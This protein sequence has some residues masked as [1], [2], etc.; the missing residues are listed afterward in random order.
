M[1]LTAHAVAHTFWYFILIVL[2]KQDQQT[3]DGAY[4]T[5]GGIAGLWHG[6]GS[7]AGAV[8]SWLW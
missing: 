3:P 6:S 2:L 4:V 1:L 5:G 7:V 8:A